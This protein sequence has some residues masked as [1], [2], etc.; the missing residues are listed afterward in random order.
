MERAWVQ[1]WAAQG[2]IQSVCPL[3]AWWV[4]WGCQ[5][6]PCKGRSPWVT[7]LKRRRVR[8]RP[9]LESFRSLP[10]PVEADVSRSHKALLLLCIFFAYQSVS[11]ASNSSPT[12]L[13]RSHGHPPLPPPNLSALLFPCLGLFWLALCFPP[14]LPWL[15]PAHYF[16][17][18]PSSGR[19]W[20][21]LGTQVQVDVPVVM[22]ESFGDSG[23]QKCE[24]LSFLPFW[25]WMPHTVHGPGMYSSLVFSR[26]RPFQ[27]I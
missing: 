2:G 12:E 4:K 24:Q 18:T 26:A 23:A 6:L 15:T 20:E 19:F 5:W 17:V 22:W 13:F 3:W 27:V 7:H 8:S 16:E 14:S 1:Q 11:P 10:L 9:S 21:N 25:G